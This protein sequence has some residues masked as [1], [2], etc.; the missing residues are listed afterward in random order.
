MDRSD[1]LVPIKMIASMSVLRQSLK[2]F[3]PF[4]SSALA[5]EKTDKPKEEFK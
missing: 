4:R 2:S 3:A 5:R 1:G